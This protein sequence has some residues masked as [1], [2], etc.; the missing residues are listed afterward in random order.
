[1]MAW[2]VVYQIKDGYEA[3]FASSPNKATAEQWAKELKEHGIATR[4]DIIHARSEY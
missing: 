2:Y 1:M 3:W 4:I